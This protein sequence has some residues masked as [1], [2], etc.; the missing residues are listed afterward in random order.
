MNWG[1]HENARMIGLPKDQLFLSDYDADWVAEFE[2]E[3]K[4]ILECI[5]KHVSA[6]HHIGS[7]AVP[8][9]R[10]KPIIDIAIE[11]RDFEDGFHCVEPLAEIGYKHKI[12]PELPE[13]HYLSKGDVRTHQIHMYKPNSVYLKEQLL[14][15]DKLRQNL[16][17]AK[18]YEEIKE[19]LAIKYAGDRLAYAEVKTDF[20]KTSLSSP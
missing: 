8:G 12:I 11:L 1:I 3:S 4:S 7:T 19:Q 16:K 5:G 17:L 14:F 9:L 6:I 10:A 20:I 2:T 13:R 15:R 18:D